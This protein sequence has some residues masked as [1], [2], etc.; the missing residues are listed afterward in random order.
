[1]R[2]YMIKRKEMPMPRLTKN[3]QLDSDLTG[4]SPNPDPTHNVLYVLKQEVDRMND[5]QAAESRRVSEI[6]AL[7]SKRVQEQMELRAAYE[8][9]LKLA[10]T[11]RIDSIRAVDVAAVGVAT[12]K[13]NQQAIVLA[14][15]VA[16]SAEALRA[17]VAS[18]ATTV[19]SQLQQMS[20]QLSDRLSIVEKSQ[21]EK[22]G[23]GNGIKNFYGWIIAALMA[24]V[25]IYGAMKH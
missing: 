20:S 6:N 13:A 9:K 12:E 19:A 25:T 15:Q 24:A 22:Q 7:E 1:M 8:E 2:F 21:Y 14:N 23:S 10:E 3:A 17:L 11:K 4:L 18:T 5:L 16:T